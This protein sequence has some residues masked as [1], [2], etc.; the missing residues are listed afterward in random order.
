MC[1]HLILGIFSHS[2]LFLTKSKCAFCRCGSTPHLELYDITWII[3][4]F[5]TDL[6]IFALLTNVCLCYV[7]PVHCPTGAPV[8]PE[9]HI[10]LQKSNDSC[11]TK[12]GLMSGETWGDTKRWCLFPVLYP[13]NGKLNSNNFLYCKQNTGSYWHVL[14]WYKKVWSLVWINGLEYTSQAITSLCVFHVTLED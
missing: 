2:G 3:D 14:H 9:H 8:S 7:L 10:N 11:L 6:N 12:N 5:S 4:M 13:N 1:F